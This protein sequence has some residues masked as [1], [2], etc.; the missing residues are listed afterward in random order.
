[1]NAEQI[2]AAY[3]ETTNRINAILDEDRKRNEE[4]DRE[5]ENMTAQRELERKLFWRQKE[6]RAGKVK[7]DAAGEVKEEKD[8]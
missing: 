8:A 6:E 5:V 3:M 1:M 2:E 7:A 4:I